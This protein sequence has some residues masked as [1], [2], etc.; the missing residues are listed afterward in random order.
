MY[1]II[2]YIQICIQMLLKRLTVVYMS[3]DWHTLCAAKTRPN[4]AITKM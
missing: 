4:H 3:F 1:K 2:I